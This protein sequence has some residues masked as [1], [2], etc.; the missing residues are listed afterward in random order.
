MVHIDS[1]EAL[2]FFSRPPHQNFSSDGDFM[3]YV[4]FLDL[5]RW[6]ENIG[7][8]DRSSFAPGAGTLLLA[9]AY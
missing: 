7:I 8:G 5:T 9:P 3:L 6:F 1:N 2:I 4:S